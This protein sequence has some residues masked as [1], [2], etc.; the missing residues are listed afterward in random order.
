MGTSAPGE[1][2]P[3]EPEVAVEPKYRAFLSYSHSDAPIA[4]AI[5]RWLEGYRVPRHLVGRSTARGVAPRRLTPIFMDRSELAASASLSGAVDEALAASACLIV[6]CSPAARESAWVDLEIRRFRQLHP[7]RPVLA[8][9]VGGT[10]QT[11]FPPGICQPRSSGAVDEPAAADFTRHGDGRLLAYLKLVAGVIGVPLDLLVQRHV[12]RRLRRV[13]IATALATL[14]VLVL[15]VAL[16]M[17]IRAQREAEQQREQAEQLIEFMLTDLRGRLRGVGR[18]DV[19]DVVNRRAMAY[20]AAQGDLA[21]LPTGSLER[22]ARVLHA[23][24]EDEQRSGAFATAAAKFAEAH[25]ATAA[26]LAAAPDDPERLYAHAQSEFWLGYV[27][28]MRKARPAAS[29][30]FARYKALA[31]RLVAADRNNPAYRRELAYAHGNLCSVE[32]E[33][34]R[35]LP[36]ALQSCA[37]AL[38]TMARL[39]AAA[40][41]DTALR[42][43]LANRHAWMAQALE[44][45]GQITSALA[46]RHRQIAIL[47]RLVAGDPRNARIRQDAALARFSLAQILRKSGAEARAVEMAGTAHAAMAALQRSDPANRDWKTWNARI[48]QQFPSNER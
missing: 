16:I 44:A 39:S 3:A 12:Q 21:A 10:P 11:A 27:A 37:S 36:A 15:A 22:R 23:M 18:L 4:R 19:L 26:L 20:Y 47:D 2:P 25:Q 28:F 43:D 9:L 31:L 30:H 42:L 6:L 38:A 7:D 34:Q 46:Q 48:E 40:P 24:G 17:A 14:S 1:T 29:A 13:A 33:D 45:N 41:H 32:V 35:T 5:H 8:A